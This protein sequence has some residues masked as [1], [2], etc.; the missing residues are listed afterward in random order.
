M[1][2]QIPGMSIALAVHYVSES[3]GSTGPGRP[4]R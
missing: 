1:P 3:I 2:L 4:T